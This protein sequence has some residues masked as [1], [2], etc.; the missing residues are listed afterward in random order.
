M[1]AIPEKQS[2]GQ[3]QLTNDD[4]LTVDEAAAFLKIS[5]PSIYRLIRAGEIPCRRV[6]KRWRFSRRALLAWV[7]RED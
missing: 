3:P 2:G 4:I 5:R 7:E 6:G 1:T